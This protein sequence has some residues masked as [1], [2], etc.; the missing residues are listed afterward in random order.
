MFSPLDSCSGSDLHRMFPDWHKSNG[1]NTKFILL[2]SAL[3]SHVV[4]FESLIS[5]CRHNVVTAFL[6]GKV[7]WQTAGQQTD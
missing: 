2:V 3:H 6:P 1:V 5:S 4:A 7:L